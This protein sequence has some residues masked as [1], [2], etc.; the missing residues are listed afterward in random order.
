M[1]R[2]FDQLSLPLLRWLDAEDAH[3]LAIQGLKLLPAIKPRPDDAKLAVRAFGL[4]FPNPVGM[5]A[6]FDKNAEVPDALLRL[7]F[8]FVEI[9]SVTP[10]P[11]SGNPRPRLFRLERDEA[12][13]NRMGFNN[14]GAEIVLRRLAGRA[15]QGGIVGVNVGANK[16]SADR[17]ADYV[18][19]IETFAPVASYFTVNI[20]S[21]NT[22]GLRNLQQAAQLNELL[23]KVLEARDRVRRKAGDTP[24]LLKIAPDL[25]LAELD[26]VVHVARSRG[27]DGMIVSNTTLARPNSLREQ[28][29]AKEQG[30]L[31]GR[32]LF[33]LSTRMVAETFV[34]V[35]GAF[36]LIGVG[37]IDSGGAAL[38]KIRAGASLIQLYSSLV[39]KGLGLVESIK[40]DLTS[41]LLRTGRDSLS[42]IVG[43]DAATITAEDW[44][45]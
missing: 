45:V 8:G 40:A 17:V 19:L 21:P 37:G 3:R 20:S 18:R 30:G 32:P 16:D 6:G 33:R 26:D 24:V 22:P 25:S 27:V 12:V 11:Q 38:T 42:E 43:A 7:G 28:L 36:P 10:R 31:S 44:P 41:T 23:S 35:E 9:G 13:V 5:A 2:A 4:N 14:D 39:Y 29:R 34:R 1:I 15:N